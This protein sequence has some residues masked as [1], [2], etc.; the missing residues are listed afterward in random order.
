MADLSFIKSDVGLVPADEWAQEWF[1][2]LR[3]GV[4]VAAKVRVPR[5]QRFHR[6]FFAMLNVAY[7]NHDWP[8]IQTQFGPARCSFDQFRKYVTIKAGFFTMGATPTGEPRAEAKSISFTKMDEAEFERVYSEVLNVILRE[9]LTNWK[10]GDMENAVNQMM[11][12]A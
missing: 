1:Q 10:Y 5:N 9:F 4:T 3:R 2:K 6:K 8:E 12:F 7:E 11:T